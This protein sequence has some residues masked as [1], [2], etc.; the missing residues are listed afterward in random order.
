MGEYI[1]R[2]RPGGLG[3]A[4]LDKQASKFNEEEAANLL[5]WIKDLTKE[6]F[7]ATGT[8]Q[9][10]L[11]LLKDGQLL[12]RFINAVQPGMI[13]KIMKPISN[14]N[15]MENINMF[16]NCVR[17]L[18]VIDEETFQSVDLFEG[19]DLFS[20][21]VT[22]QSLGRKLEKIHGIAGPKQIPKNK[23]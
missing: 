7:D 3:G 5:Q 6:D 22:L 17:K 16:T 10:F 19:R 9:N 20:V 1:H 8:R 12:C 4:V 14:F 21:C 18:G 2:P 23:I 15:C 13:K 11:A